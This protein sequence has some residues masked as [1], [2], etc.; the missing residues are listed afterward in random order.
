MSFKILLIG[1]GL[2]DNLGGPSLLLSTKAIFK[3]IFGEVDYTYITTVPKDLK[4]ADQFGMKIISAQPSWKIFPGVL[5]HTLFK[6]RFHS[7]E[8]NKM[9]DAFQEAD[10]VVDIRGITFAETVGKSGFFQ[11]AFHGFHFL[12]GKKFAKPVIKYTADI[13]PF[14]NF[15]TK[16]FARYYFNNFVDLIMARSEQ[17][18]ENLKQIG[19][20]TPIYIVPDSAFL[21]EAQETL[22][23]HD[24]LQLR[25]IKPVVGISLSYMA[26]RHASVG[27][28][29]I[30]I[31]ADFSD[32]LVKKY[33][34]K[35]LLIPNQV[36]SNRKADDRIVV[37]EVYYRVHNHEEIFMVMEN[38]TAS[39]LKGVLASCDVI[40]SARYH[41]IVAALSLGIPVIAIGWHHKYESVMGLFA[42]EKYVF[43][44]ND[45]R[46]EELMISFDELWENR[47]KIRDQIKQSFPAVRESVINGAHQM[48]K[49]IGLR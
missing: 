8:I 30:Q 19:V 22:L 1:V 23:S 28:E 18:A 26:Q 4:L 35:V 39:E 14:G 45:L 38:Y 48:E 34:A 46:L 17:S 13:G 3:E 15:W 25:N 24:I 20:Q 33:D 21:L 5:L 31:M 29:Y 44:V 36:S 9:I 6:M 41:S 37:R 11:R 47:E 10:C 42:Q 12:L 40:V 27:Q 7:S 49:I 2:S 32:W 16:F 43:S